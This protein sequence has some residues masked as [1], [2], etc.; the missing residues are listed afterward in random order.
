MYLCPFVS[1]QTDG[2]VP[3]F[4]SVQNRPGKRKLD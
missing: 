4:L 2:V 3:E 1:H